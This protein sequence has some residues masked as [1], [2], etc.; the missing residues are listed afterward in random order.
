MDFCLHNHPIIPLAV[1]L[2][3]G[4]GSDVHSCTLGPVLEVVAIDGGCP[5]PE[6]R[7]M[8]KSLNRRTD[9]HTPTYILQKWMKITTS[10]MECGKR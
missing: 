7:N 4:E 10:A 9:G 5:L 8:W 2:A 3:G 1:S 6:E